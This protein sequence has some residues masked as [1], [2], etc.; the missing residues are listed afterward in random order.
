[1]LHTGK[2]VAVLPTT[3]PA[4]A[5]TFFSD[6]LGL[7]LVVED[8]FALTYDAGGTSL[9]VTKVEELTPH[10]FT[11]LGWW[12]DDLPGTVAALAAAGVALERYPGME[13]D[14][15][16]L[17]APP[18]SRV[19]VGWFKNPDGNTLSVTGSVA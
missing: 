10:P 9:R 16:G 14:A 7:K 5:K 11:V 2:L 13:Q 19:Q 18:G 17:W 4:R 8:P 15:A 3:D 6:V 1:M 12:V